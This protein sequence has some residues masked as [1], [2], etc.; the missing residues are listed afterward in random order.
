MKK[1]QLLTVMMVVGFGLGIQ[2]ADNI[3]FTSLRRAGMGGAGIAMTSDIHA[4]YANPAGLANAQ[5]HGYLPLG[6]ML[7]PNDQVMSKGAQAITD[8]GNAKT[9]SAKANVLTSLAPSDFAVKMALPPIGFTNP[10]FGIG[11]FTGGSS[12]F[13]VYDV[14]NPDVKISALGDAGLLMGGSVSLS[15]LD[16]PFQ[17][18]GTVKYV[19]RNRL[20]DA[21]TQSKTFSRSPSEIVNSAAAVTANIANAG[22]TGL[23]G[24]L[25]MLMPFGPG[26]LGVVLNNIGGSLS[27]SYTTSRNRT[28]T[29]SETL[30][31]L[32]GIG[33]AQV[34]DATA[35]PWFGT[36]IGTFDMAADYYFQ[37]SNAYK[38]VS[39]GLE[40]RI[41]DNRIAF[42]VG[43]NQGY[44]TFGLGFD[45]Y[46]FKLEY[47]F[48]TTEAGD[49]LGEDP[50]SYNMVEIN[51]PLY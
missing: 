12:R 15:L 35:M 44:P 39:M 28:V 36:T 8:Y 42:R 20:L 13:G 23:S 5:G 33:Y 38:N 43:I 2:A 51:L 14:A 30:P 50:I 22:I 49:Y 45:L 9:D 47:A 26:Q 24:D 11:V 27:G 18:G 34:I 32:L 17:V 19:Y 40:K 21:V 10:G 3:Q 48:T 4:L 46:V 6:I 37:Y 29:Y 25:G 7:S 41:W 16:I 31:Y 1:Y